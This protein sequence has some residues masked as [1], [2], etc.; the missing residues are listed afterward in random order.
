MIALDNYNKILSIKPLNDGG[1]LVEVQAGIA[2][3]DLVIKLDQ[4]DLALINLGATATQTIVGAATTGTHG[5]GGAIGAIATQIDSMRIIDA[6]GH[7]LTAS[8][9]WNVDLYNAARVGIG[10]V[11]VISTVTLRAVPQWKMRRY[12]LAYSLADLLDGELDVLLGKYSRIQWSFTPYTDEASVMIREDVPMDTE[13]YP[14]APD[15]GC[16]T[17]TQSTSSAAGCTDLSYKTLTDSYIHYQKRSLYTEMEMFISTDDSVS[18]VKDFIRFM[19]SPQVKEKHD[20]AV[21]LSVMLRYV[22]PDD[23]FLSPMYGRN[24]SVISFIVLGDQTATGPY[25]EFQMYAKG[26]NMCFSHVCSL[27]SVLLKYHPFSQYYPLLSYLTTI[28]TRISY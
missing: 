10:A 27:S 24:T 3:R 6:N 16:W 17:E 20:P 26:S 18:A 19:D 23:I 21:T 11:G 22:A 15:G 4:H 14:P 12:S 13:V 9:E 7:V 8:T 2:L 1:A 25:E 28:L 5:T